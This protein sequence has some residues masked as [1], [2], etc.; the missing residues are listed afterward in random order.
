MSDGVIPHLRFIIAGRLARAY[1]ILPGPE[2]LEDTPAGSAFYAAAGV[3]IWENGVGAV[4]RVGSDYPEEWL[5]KASMKG[6]DMRGIRRI[7]EPIDLRYFSAFPDFETKIIENPVATYADLGLLFPKSLLGYAPKANQLDSRS[8]PTLLTIRQ[9]DLPSDYLDATAAHICPLDYLS[10][11]LLPPTLRSG[12]INTITLDPGEGYMDSTFYDDMPII[13]S[14]L[15]AFLC[16]EEK[17]S[18]LFMGRTVDLWEMAED[19][20]RMGCDLIVIKRGAAGQFLYDRNSRTRW[21]VPAYPARISN[22]TGAGDAF[23]GGFLVGYQATY[24]PITA[25]LQGNI[26]A[27]FIIEGKS[28]FYALDAM[29]G[30]AAARLQSLRDKVRRA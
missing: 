25:V 23:C 17:L 4:A 1:T 30:L 2:V 12:H 6:F 27:S 10:H 13:L 18:R 3:T 20:A 7:S 26:S 22:L 14:G 19:L 28:P 11:T 8:R 5:E 9:S 16:N 21:I 29:P 24:D 15:T